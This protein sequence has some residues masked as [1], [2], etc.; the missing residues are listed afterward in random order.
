MERTCRGAKGMEPLAI[1]SLTC[2]L[3][4]VRVVC[5]VLCLAVGRKCYPKSP[6]FSFEIFADLEE[7]VACCLQTMLSL[8][9]WFGG[10]EKHTF[11]S[12]Q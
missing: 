11:V 12:A 7:H 10:R 8:S 5:G 2:C 6:V 1:P 9:W 4:M 3:V